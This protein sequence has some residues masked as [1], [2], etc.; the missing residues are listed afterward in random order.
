LGRG[1]G[2]AHEGPA[3]DGPEEEEEAM[4]A[5]STT[6][7]KGLLWFVALS[8]LA[9]GLAIM[10]SPGLQQL[11]AGV[12]GADVT[13]TPELVYLL[14]PMGVF[15]VGLG[16]L[17][18]AAALDPVRYRAVVFAFAIVLLLRVGQRLVHRDEIAQAFDLSV[19]RQMVNGS[20]FLVVALALLA[21]SFA[22]GRSRPE[23]AASASASSPAPG[24]GA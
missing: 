4:Q 11:M 13:W 23:G 18:V 21:L 7:L 20:F 15:M 1:D 19:G 10:A 9:V 16:L 8:H 22:A 6:A 12:Y 24:H 5:K 17:G 2:I 14:R 3:D